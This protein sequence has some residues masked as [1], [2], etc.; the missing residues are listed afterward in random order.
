MLSM[1]ATWSTYGKR[2]RIAAGRD[3]LRLAVSSGTRL[4]PG[5]RDAAIG[6]G[7]AVD[8]MLALTGQLSSVQIA[9]VVPP[10]P[11]QDAERKATDVKLDEITALVRESHP[12]AILTTSCLLRTRIDKR[13][14]FSSGWRVIPNACSPV[15]TGRFI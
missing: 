12:D 13:H 3:G 8:K 14:A 9:N 10:T 2:R 1:A 6:T 5:L 4:R 7:I 15:T 11:E